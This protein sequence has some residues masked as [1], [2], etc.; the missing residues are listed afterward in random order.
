M[1]FQF[2]FLIIASLVLLVIGFLDK[3][4]SKLLLISKD[5]ILYNRSKH[6][7]L[8]ADILNVNPLYYSRITQD[9]LFTKQ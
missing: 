1:N 2:F 5:L 7:F 4:I 9:F 6:F 3:R 8:S